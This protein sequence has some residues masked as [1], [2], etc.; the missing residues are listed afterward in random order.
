[1]VTKLLLQLTSKGWSVCLCP[2]HSKRFR[3]ICVLAL[4]STLVLSARGEVRLPALFSDNMVLQQNVPAP[5]W[6]WADEGETVK[7]SF[8]GKTASTKAKG[9]K[10]S[11][12]LAR[13]KAGGPD[14]LVI[15]GK[16]KI[17]LKNVLVGEV[18][19]C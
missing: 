7:V 8:R 18:W 6:G 10:W 9:G 11:V 16:N 3:H 14:D 19:I 5:V 13:L 12:R 17:E 15:E 1:M 2:M 4:A